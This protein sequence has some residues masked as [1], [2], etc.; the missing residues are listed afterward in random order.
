MDSVVTTPATTEA[1]LRLLNRRP[2]WGLSLRGWLVFGSVAAALSFGAVF[3]VYPFLAITARAPGDIL[4]VEGWVHEYAIQAAVA[5]YQ[6]GRYQLIVTTG[7]PTEGIGGYINDYSTNAA[8]A[9][10]R[11]RS[12]GLPAAVIAMAPARFSSRD[13]TYGAAVALREWLSVHAPQ[14]NRVDVLTADAHARRT[15]LLF[16]TALGERCQVGI[17]AVR[18]PDFDGHRWWLYSEGCRTVVAEAIGY[19]YARLWFVPARALAPSQA[20]SRT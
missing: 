14:V 12:S 17:I 1:C 4:V 19:L 11:L 13:R 7:G 2:R 20:S 16:Q 5:E 15:R 3:G 6:H 9:A 10:G 8:I 18:S